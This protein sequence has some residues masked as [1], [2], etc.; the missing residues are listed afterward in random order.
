MV[1]D[2][3][4]TGTSNEDELA[5]VVATTL[6]GNYPNPFNPETTISY[7]VKENTPVTIDIY[8]V[9]GQRVRTLVN[10]AKASGTH[11]VTWNGTD[12][13]GRNV[14]SGIYYYKMSAGKFSSTKKMILMK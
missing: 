10:E 12:N 7:S 11:T 2:F 8:N 13:N 5:P 6:H 14:S 4:V 1:D 9:K 3:K